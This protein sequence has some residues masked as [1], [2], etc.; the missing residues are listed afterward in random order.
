MAETPRWRLVATGSTF[1][2]A[3]SRVPARSRRLR[4]KVIARESSPGTSGRVPSATC[5]STTSTSSHLAHSPAT[6]GPAK[7]R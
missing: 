6:S 4:A 7:G 3:R 2:S 5:H 1:A